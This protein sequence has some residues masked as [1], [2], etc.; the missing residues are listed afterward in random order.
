MSIQ[1]KMCKE[2]I[3]QL[4]SMAFFPQIF[5]LQSMAFFF[6]GKMCWPVQVPKISE[7]NIWN[8]W[9]KNENSAQWAHEESVQLGD[10]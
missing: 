6:Q 7:L 1:Q 5:Q 3:F 10:F 9:S 8:G 2:E 4:Q